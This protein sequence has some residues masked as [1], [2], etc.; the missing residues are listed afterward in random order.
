[1]A[2]ASKSRS[3]MVTPPPKSGVKG[4]GEKMYS[5]EE[6]QQLLDNFDC[7]GMSIVCIAISSPT[8][9]FFMTLEIDRNERTAADRQS[10]TRSDPSRHTY[11]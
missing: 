3:R 11:K 2:T 7:E 4:G 5:R 6:K 1:M 10:K 9:L 8:L